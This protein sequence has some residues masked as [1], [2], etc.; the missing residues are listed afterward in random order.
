MTRLR[1]PRALTTIAA[2]FTLSLTAAAPAFAGPQVNGPDRGQRSLEFPISVAQAEQRADARFR[3]LDA[4]GSGEI[5]LEEFQAA[6]GGKGMKMLHRAG[7]PRWDGRRAGTEDD[8]FDR[9]D[10]NGDGVLS[11]DEFD[12]DNLRQARRSDRL[13]AVFQHLDKD[14]SGGLSREELP[15]RGHR[16]SAMDTDGD[17]LVTREE[18]MAYRKAMGSKRH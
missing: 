1:K 16:L 13:E 10:S 17:G 2:A 11:R 7:S 6:G 15:D 9:L 5:S 18:A 14:G 8:L 4:D 12:R 3:E